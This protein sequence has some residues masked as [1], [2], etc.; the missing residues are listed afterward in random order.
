MSMESKCW[1]AYVGQ[2]NG[3]DKNNIYTVAKRIV[4]QMQNEPES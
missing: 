2:C 3:V 4:P 1:Q